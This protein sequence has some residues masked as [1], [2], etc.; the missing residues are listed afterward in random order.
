MAM[1]AAR[2]AAGKTVRQLAE[3][4][5]LAIGSVSNY[6]NG[7]RMPGVREL[8]LIEGALGT[9]GRLKEALDEWAED[10]SPEWSAWRDIEEHADMLFSYDHSVVPGFLQ[11]EDYAREVLSHD[12]NSPLELEQRV[13]YRMERQAILDAEKPPT[14][15]AIFRESVLHTQIGSRETM[16]DQVTRIIEMAQRQDIIVQIVTLDAGY[17]SGLNGAFMIAKANGAE[18]AFQDGIWTG[19]VLKDDVAIS[20]LSSKWQHIQSKAL[21]AEAS[22]DLLKKEA[23]KWQD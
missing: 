15:V 2:D 20:A 8:D 22:L 11:T 13:Q 7:R 1:A 10:V 4:V 3:E 9:K 17:H 21:T 19:H 23:E 5:H 18:I 14:V 12:L 16:Y 6:E